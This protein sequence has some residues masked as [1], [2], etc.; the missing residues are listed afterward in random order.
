LHP[1]PLAAVAPEVAVDLQVGITLVEEVRLK[2][3]SEAASYCEQD[4]VVWELRLIYVSLLPAS[5]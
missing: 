5:G 3:V 2:Q 1:R 4:Q